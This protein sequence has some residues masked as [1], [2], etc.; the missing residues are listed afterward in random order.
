[1]SY[2]ID[3]S[4]DVKITGYKVLGRFRGS[5]KISLVLTNDQ[6]Q[7][8]YKTSPLTATQMAVYQNAL[9]QLISEKK[10]YLNPK[11]KKADLAQA[12]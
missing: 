2:P 6:E 9:L 4:D 5:P 8:K 12:S 1:M 10:P 11:L 3:G 7:D